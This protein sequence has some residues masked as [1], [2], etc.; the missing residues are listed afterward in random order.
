MMMA[1]GRSIARIQRVPKAA[2]VVALQKF[3][4]IKKMIMA[5][6]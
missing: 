5:M 1:M 4:I 3:V 2:N 6:V